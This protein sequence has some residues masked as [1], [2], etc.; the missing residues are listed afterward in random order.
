MGAIGSL[1]LFFGSLGAGAG[2]LGSYHAMQKL[3]LAFR[4]VAYNTLFRRRGETM[5]TMFG[6][7]E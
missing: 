1:H 2:G 5:P 4:L 7:L 3:L 6:C